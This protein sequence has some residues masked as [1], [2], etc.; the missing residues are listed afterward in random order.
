MKFIF[1]ALFVF[2]FYSFQAQAQSHC[3]TTLDSSTPAEL[4]QF[5]KDY[6]PFWGTWRGVYNGEPV[7][8]EFYV[9]KQ[10][11]FNIKGTYKTTVLNDHKIKLC[12]KNKKF[13]AVVYG[14]TVNIN[15]VNS[16]RLDVS[17]FLIN[18]VITV[19]R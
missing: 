6:N 15:V 7:V 14:M 1:S 12:Y 18:G 4:K 2:S 13:Q 17:H 9:D 16:R 19:Q 11:M 5:L 8:G 10:N 3:A